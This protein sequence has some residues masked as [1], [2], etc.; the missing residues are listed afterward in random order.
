[1][2]VFAP[3]ADRTNTGRAAGGGRRGGPGAL[4]GRAGGPPPRIGSDGRERQPETEVGNRS[5]QLG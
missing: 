3:A 5:L 2:P 1:M 4:A